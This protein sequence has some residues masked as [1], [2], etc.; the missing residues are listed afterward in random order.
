MC[1]PLYWKINLQ[2]RPKRPKKVM[3]FNEKSI[4]ITAV[5]NN[6]KSL[7]DNNKLTRLGSDKSGYWKVLE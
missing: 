2:Q 3:F 6:I 4:T 1:N 7:K 5:K